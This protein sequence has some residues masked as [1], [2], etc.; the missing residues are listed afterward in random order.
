MSK[1]NLDSR[2]QMDGKAQKIDVGDKLSNG[3]LNE[4]DGTGEDE[5]ELVSETVR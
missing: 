5:E 4:R 1:I 3:N 2:G